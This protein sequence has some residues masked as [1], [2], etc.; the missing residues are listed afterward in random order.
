MEQQLFSKISPNEFQN[1]NFAR[2]DKSL[3]PN[4]HIFSEHFNNIN[5]WFIRLLMSEST[6]AG[7]VEALKSLIDLAMEFYALK[8]YNG[9]MEAAAAW[10][11]SAVF[12]L[13]KT[14]EELPPKYSPKFKA[15]SEIATNAKNYSA[16]RALLAKSNPPLVPYIGVYQ[17]DLTFVEEGNSTTVEDGRLINWQKCKMQAK[18]LLEIRSRQV[19]P[20]KIAPIPWMQEFFR[21]L[22]VDET[23]D[24]F[25]GKSLEYEPKAVAPSAFVASQMA[26]TSGFSSS[27]LS[28]SLTSAFG[29]SLGSTSDHGKASAAEGC[30]NANNTFKFL[31]RGQTTF[32]RIPY[33]LRCFECGTSGLKLKKH[34]YNH[35][36]ENNLAPQSLVDEARE[37]EK[38]TLALFSGAY[39]YGVTLSDD[40]R[41]S[42]VYLHSEK[43]FICGFKDIRD[44]EV[45]YPSAEGSAKSAWFKADADSPLFSLVVSINYAFSNTKEFMMVRVPARGERKWL[46]VNLT[47]NQ[48]EFGPNDKIIIV[49]TET[50]FK[51]LF[52]ERTKKELA[53]MPDNKA[54]FFAKNNIRLYTR[55]AKITYS[56]AKQRYDESLINVDDGK[57]MSS[58][59]R[60]SMSSST[61]SSASLLSEKNWFLVT[62]GILYYF[63]D[64]SS[65]NPRRVW[66]LEYC[67]IAIEY[68]HRTPL[69]L[70]RI[71]SDYPFALD[72]SQVVYL[73]ARN[74]GELRSWYDLLQKRSKRG[75]NTALFGVSMGLISARTTTESFFPIQIR[76]CMEQIMARGLDIENLFSS[77]PQQAL[78]DKYREIIES[79]GYPKAPT[80]QADL[81]ALA[82]IVRAYFAE[83]PEP[84][85]TYEMCSSALK[86]VE[87][88]TEGSKFAIMAVVAALPSPAMFGLLYLVSMLRAWASVAGSIPEAAKILSQ[89]I[90]AGSSVDEREVAENSIIIAEELLE[91]VIS[92]RVPKE[93]C[94]FKH[95]ARMNSIKDLNMPITV[96]SQP[97]LDVLSRMVTSSVAVSNAALSDPSLTDTTGTSVVVMA[98]DDEDDE[99]DDEDEE[100]DDGNDE[101]D[102]D[103]D[104]DKSDDDDDDSAGKSDNAKSDGK[105]D[106]N[107]ADELISNSLR[108]LIDLQKKTIHVKRN[109]VD[110]ANNGNNN[111]ETSAKQKKHKYDY[112]G[113]EDVVLDKTHVAIM[114]TMSKDIKNLDK[115][116]SSKNSKVQTAPI[117]Y[118]PV[119]N[120]SLDSFLIAKKHPREITIYLDHSTPP[121]PN[122][123]PSSFLQN[124]KK[125]VSPSSSSSLPC[126]LCSSSSSSSPSSTTSQTQ[127]PSSSS[128]TTTRK[129]RGLI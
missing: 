46:N 40:K 122:L 125:S 44:V 73:S 70:I 129:F 42:L 87:L 4:N 19:V 26:S 76:R 74:E 13:H 128:S 89:F 94:V 113:I 92:V 68:V 32:V 102:D 116:K 6:V 83:L 124:S 104:D 108:T 30:H 56:T 48:Q 75:Y 28:S 27:A 115:K 10:S 69:L 25:W 47:L 59:Q 97:E 57:C 11:N 18:I 7:R 64:Y 35:L 38:V 98:G 20:Y 15:I 117:E 22:H 78:V 65:M 123:T 72:R 23:D 79:G 111:N 107:G 81:I 49:F 31:L 114:K 54:G 101:D 85:I 34:I 103:D 17:T 99:D 5:K 2:K 51:R 106:A 84:F 50:F 41:Y 8:N 67:S 62:D 71:P 33:P 119:A 39:R 96:F 29:P 90:A 63:K 53:K 93:K 36:R 58:M 37:Q 86:G 82:S 9:V 60:L 43:A 52:P 120:A 61:L 12:R 105:N 88:R 24:Y 1:L 21:N 100:D 66:A 110:P 121:P 109:G 95:H 112:S 126:P 45:V 3:A 118:S 77:T 55:N 91:Y 80:Q 127:N 14:W 16:L